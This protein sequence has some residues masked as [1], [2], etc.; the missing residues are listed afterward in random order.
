MTGVL[1]LESKLLPLVLQYSSA[2]LQ[3]VPSVFHPFFALKK[4]I[5]QSFLRYS[6]RFLVVLASIHG[7][8]YP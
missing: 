4:L 3:W 5:I 1:P 6:S 2:E 7:Y 8:M